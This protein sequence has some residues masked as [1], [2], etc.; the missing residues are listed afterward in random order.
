MKCLLFQPFS[1][2][3]LPG[4]GGDATVVIVYDVAHIKKSECDHK[5][6]SSKSKIKYFLADN[7]RRGGVFS[8]DTK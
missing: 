1:R 4:V 3:L 6:Q 2:A 8:N 7:E 5:Y